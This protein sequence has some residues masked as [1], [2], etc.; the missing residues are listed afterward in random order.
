MKGYFSNRVII[1]I[2]ILFALVVLPCLAEDEIVNVMDFGAYANGMLPPGSGT[3]P[4]ED[5]QLEGRVAASAS[6][7]PASRAKLNTADR[8]PATITKGTPRRK[9]KVVCAFV[10]AA[11][12]AEE[13]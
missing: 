3:L 4:V 10:S 11:K 8:T 13:F 1:G 6:G 2:I 5:P 9:E 12:A 7:S